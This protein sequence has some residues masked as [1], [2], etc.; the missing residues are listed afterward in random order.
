MREL[1]GDNVR[2]RVVPVERGW[3]ASRMRKL[4]SV[5]AGGFGGDSQQ[6]LAFADDLVSAVE[7]R[8]LWSRFGL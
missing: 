7:L 5:L 1:H 2:L 8:A 4:P 3:L 6:G